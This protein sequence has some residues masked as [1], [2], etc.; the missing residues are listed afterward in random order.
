MLA[1]YILAIALFAVNCVLSLYI[2]A[3]FS[4]RKDMEA[5]DEHLRWTE[6]FVEV[7]GDRV[8]MLTDEELRER[9]ERSE[10]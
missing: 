9:N 7:F 8:N 5:L 6:E 2:T 3:F 4:W 1:W 10:R